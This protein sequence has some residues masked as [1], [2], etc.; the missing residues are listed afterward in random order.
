VAEKL[1]GLTDA[2][3]A[4]LRERIGVPE[5][6]WLAVKFV[7][8]CE[9]F[10]GRTID[11]HRLLFLLSYSG[12]G[13]RDEEVTFEGTA[14]HV[15]AAPA[16]EPSSARASVHE[17]GTVGAYPSIGGPRLRVRQALRG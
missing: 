6:I 10:N 5:D 3:V 15:D 14:D 17:D 8:E 4:R 9:Y 11:V 16:L 12:D 7:I 13:W 1:E 2:G